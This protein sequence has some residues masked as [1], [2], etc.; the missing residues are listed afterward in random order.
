L[1]EHAGKPP[2]GAVL[3]KTVELEFSALS[4]QCLDRRIAGM[5]LLEAEVNAWV[6]HRNE[7]RVSVD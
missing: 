3:P 1:V 4:K 2:P 6:A 7:K 5:G